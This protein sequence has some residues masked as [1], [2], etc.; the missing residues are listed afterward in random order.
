MTDAGFGGRPRSAG[1]ARP[2]PP[3][4]NHPTP[5]GG[6]SRYDPGQGGSSGLYAGPSLRA[7]APDSPPPPPLGTPAST[8]VVGPEGLTPPPGGGG[9]A[10][11]RPGGCSSC[12]TQGGAQKRR[13]ASGGWP[14]GGSDEGRA[15]H[16]AHRVARGSLRSQAPGQAYG[17]YGPGSLT[18]YVVPCLIRRRRRPTPAGPRE[19]V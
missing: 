6:F 10:G 12:A 18:L 3:S 14:V 5:G 1:F 13:G 9:L 16:V 15:P 11:P 7:T 19:D 2:G 4:A 8:C 17:R